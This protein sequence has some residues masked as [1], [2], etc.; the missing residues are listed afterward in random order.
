MNPSTRGK[1]HHF[2]QELAALK[3]ELVTMGGLA[4]AAVRRSIPSR[5]PRLKT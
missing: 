3:D 2:D 5:R 1:T 4:E